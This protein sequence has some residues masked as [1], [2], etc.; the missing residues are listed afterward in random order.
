MDALGPI[1]YCALN[2][3]LDA[4]FPA[5]G[6][7]YWKS[8][9]VPDL[10]DAVIDQLVTAYETCPVPTGQILIEH[11]HGAAARVPVHETAYALRDTGF[12]TLVLGHFTERAREDETISWCR[13]TFAAIQPYAGARRFLNYLGDDEAAGTLAAAAYGPN[14]A[15]LSQ[16][17]KRY[18]P[19]NMFHLNLNIPAG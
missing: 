15:R 5:G 1:S 6:L 18:D 11:F 12:N 17:K 14:L 7:D 10:E 19:E 3:M 13:R 9:F 2:G 4:G 16:L 8:A